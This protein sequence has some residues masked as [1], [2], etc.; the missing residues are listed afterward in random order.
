MPV[1]AR[2]ALRN[3]KALERALESASVAR[4]AD[5][6]HIDQITAYSR[7][8][9]YACATSVRTIPIKM[10]LNIYLVSEHQ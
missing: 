6:K 3:A 2:G 1:P 10:T 5:E 7:L 4:K 9:I 8:K